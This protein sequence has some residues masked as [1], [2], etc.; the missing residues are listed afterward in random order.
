MEPIGSIRLKSPKLPLFPPHASLQNALL[1]ASVTAPVRDGPGPLLCA[2]QLVA[3]S[4]A[5]APA[6]YVQKD[7][8]DAF[9]PLNFSISAVRVT[10]HKHRSARA[11]RPP[12]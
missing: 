9:R 1:D 11:Q 3:H 4:V 8:G 10:P 6:L 2:A 12:R 5:E 7:L